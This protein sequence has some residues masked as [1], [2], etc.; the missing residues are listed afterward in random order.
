MK[1]IYDKKDDRPATSPMK[2]TQMS[3]ERAPPLPPNAF[4]LI[5]E[6]PSSQQHQE[7]ASD[8]AIVNAKKK[9]TDNFEP[10]FGLTWRRY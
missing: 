1:Q 3:Y 6:L 4:R 5:R 9:E 2:Y 10:R 7:S 8:N